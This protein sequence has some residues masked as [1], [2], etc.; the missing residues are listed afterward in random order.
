MRFFSSTGL[1][2]LVLVSILQQTSARLRTS[3][4]DHVK[5]VKPQRALSHQELSNRVFDELQRFQD[6][7]VS[8]A[9]QIP[10]LALTVHRIVVEGSAGEGEAFHDE[11]RRRSLKAL[12]HGSKRFLEDAAEKSRTMQ[13]HFSAT[14]SD[15]RELQAAKKITVGLI[16]FVSFVVLMVVMFVTNLVSAAVDRPLIP[17]FESPPEFLKGTPGGSFSNIN[18]CNRVPLQLSALPG[19]ANAPLFNYV[20]VAG[21]FMR[22]ILQAA[23]EVGNDLVPGLISFFELLFTTNTVLDDDQNFPPNQ[24]SCITADG[25][26]EFTGECCRNDGFVVNC[27]GE[28]AGTSKVC[29]N[30]ALASSVNASSFEPF[31]FLFSIA[32]NGQFVDT[33]SFVP[34]TS[35]PPIQL[36][37]GT[38][39]I[40]PFCVGQAGLGCKLCEFHSGF[41]VAQFP[42]GP[43]RFMVTFQWGGV[44]YSWADKAKLA[45]G[46][47]AALTGTGDSS[48]PEIW[49]GFRSFPLPEVCI[50]NVVCA[51]AVTCLSFDFLSL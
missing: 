48:T 44:A 18:P 35:W 39:S 21:G 28:D 38:P 17:A 33:M 3:L 20:P 41:P 16:L 49:D 23:E 6:K 43:L 2:V 46:T 27:G 31:C 34:L 37:P 26:C 24:A 13:K 36:V 45:F 14:S 11:A 32:D 4:A 29:N 22:T 25:T 40:L 30:Q 5:S 42:I 9:L 10:N 51:R 8:S 7:G 19:Q 1:R 12:Q 50:L 15:H 47:N